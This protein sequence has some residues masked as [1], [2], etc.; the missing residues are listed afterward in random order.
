M[1]SFILTPV[2]LSV[3]A[4]SALV[5][6]PR[7]HVM[8]NGPSSCPDNPAAHLGRSDNGVLRKLTELPPAQTYASVYRR[9]ADGCMVPVLYRDRDAPPA[10]ASRR[11]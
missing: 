11:P 8:V 3:V 1:R 9:G 4:A 6:A 5:A 10:N 7:R 2:I